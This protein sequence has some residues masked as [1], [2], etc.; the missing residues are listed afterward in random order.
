MIHTM[1]E[2]SWKFADFCVFSVA[3]TEKRFEA[4]G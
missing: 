1:G 3:V 2:L 4:C